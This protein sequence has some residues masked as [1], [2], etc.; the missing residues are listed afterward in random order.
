ML[1]RY[2]R[3]P[4]RVLDVVASGTL[5]LVLSP[6]IA[7]VAVLVRRKLGA[8]VLFRQE[9]TGRQ[10]RTFEMV[11]FRTMTDGRSPDGELL[12]DGDRL[13]SFGAF[14]RRSSLDELPELWNVLRGDMSL[15]GPR[16]LPVRY[17]PHF[18]PEERARF[19]VRPG[20]TGLAQVSGRNAL[21]WDAR[22]ALDVEYA[23]SCSFLLDASILVRTIVVALRRDGLIV[24]P[25]AAMANFDVERS[26]PGGELGGG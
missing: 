4:K 17:T 8:P 20:I 23:T 7:S 12:P 19:D 21:S 1:T 5:L 18:T 2:S 14:L 15:I 16:P 26:T 3:A 10:E 13:T 22:F 11:K 24:D 6:V 25:G 9:R